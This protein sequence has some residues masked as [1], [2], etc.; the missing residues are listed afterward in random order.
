MR[1]FTFLSSLVA[2]FLFCTTTMAQVTLV[3]EL[4]NKGVLS[5]TDV[6]SLDA[7]QEGKWYV[8]ENDLGAL[9]YAYDDGVGLKRKPVNTHV[10][11]GMATS[12][13][14]DGLFRI[15]NRTTATIGET[16]VVGFNMQ[17][18]TGRYTKWPTDHNVKMQTSADSPVEATGWVY[19]AP[20][21]LNSNTWFQLM[22]NTNSEFANGRGDIAA[23]KNIMID[24][25]GANSNVVDWSTGSTTVVNTSATRGNGFWRIYE[26]TLADLVDVTIEVKKSGE[27]AQYT[28]K[29]KAPVGATITLKNFL[30]T[31]SFVTYE[32]TTATVQASGNNFA[33]SYSVDEDAES[34]FI[35]A[36]SYADLNNNNKWVSL[37]TQNGRMHVYDDK[38]TGGGTKKYPTIDRA[39]FTGLTDSYFW[40]FVREN[41]FSP[42]KI[43]NKGTEDEAE[44]LY[45]TSDAND[46][47]VL[48][49]NASGSVD[50]SWITD[51]WVIVK[52]HVVSGTQYFGICAS[53]T[54]RYINNNGNKGFM[55]TY[56]DGPIKDDGSNV[57]LTSELQTYTT[58]KDR[59]LNAPFNAVY[60]L[61]KEA[62]ELIRKNTTETV[63]A[64]KN[65]ISDIND[66][67]STTGFID[68]DPN[69]YYFL[70]NYTPDTERTFVLGTADGVNG[71][72]I[73]LT[74]DAEK[75]NSV[76]APM[77]CSNVNAIWKIETKEGAQAGGGS[78]TGVGVSRTIARHIKHVNSGKY[79]T[80]VE[81]ANNDDQT[82]RKLSDTKTDYYFV[83]LGAGQLFLKNVQY[84]GSGAQAMAH[85][86]SCTEHGALKAS[87]NAHYKNTRDAWYGIEATA[88]NV[89]ISDAKYA[90]TYLPFGVTVP[91][92]SALKA[93]AVTGT[94]DGVATLTEVKSVPANEGVIL[95]AETAGTYKLTIND[96]VDAWTEG[97]NKLSGSC[98][99]E[100]VTESGYVLSAPEGEVGL[101]RAEE[102][103]GSWLNNSNKAYLPV[104]NVQAGEGA[105]FLSFDFG[106]ET[107]VDVIKVAESA[108]KNAAVYDLSGRRVQS[109]QKGL[110]IVNGK[111]V[112]K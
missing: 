70:R 42:V 106:T 6:T 69:K 63:E 27:I 76:D 112:V 55:T 89:V 82:Y 7:L 29:I 28:K 12:A 84:N 52:G 4:E 1:K 46:V 74:T 110:Y 22:K 41:R 102:T 105:R 50:N 86:L 17:W 16:S 57:R 75:G 53:G 13:C 30:P 79:F 21:T 108:S 98:M 19:A 54:T 109:A 26:V 31:F 59:A 81:A 64:Y 47:P 18:G 51:E 3:N 104:S 90:T 73:E 44:T 20:L 58:L 5:V 36:T 72:T 66:G 61:N 23:G 62:R 91:E 111:K 49:H 15:T 10:V 65:I 94:A 101:Y 34:K 14:G 77:N 107:G 33:L 87:G 56:S 97:Y 48:F 71:S 92:G 24:N 39:T 35:F 38:T 96:N 100:T 88:I 43:Y 25:Q 99:S 9:S 8:M 80:A 2:A 68:F 11:S 60:S 78:S 32:N 45:L 83:N 40:G 85:S 67:N 37:F 93:Y 95:Y 103:N